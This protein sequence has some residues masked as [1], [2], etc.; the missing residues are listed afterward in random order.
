MASDLAPA[1][2]PDPAPQTRLYQRGIGLL[3]WLAF[4]VMGGAALYGLSILAGD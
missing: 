4:A 2:P 1:T 3:I